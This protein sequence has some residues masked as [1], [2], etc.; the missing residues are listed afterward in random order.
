MKTDWLQQVSARIEGRNV[1]VVASLAFC[2]FGIYV[3]RGLNPPV[4]TISLGVCFLLGAA[5]ILIALLRAPQPSGIVVGSAANPGD[6]KDLTAA[7]AQALVQ[8]DREAVTRNLLQEASRIQSALLPAGAALKRDSLT[9][10]SDSQGALASSSSA[11]APE[12]GGTLMPPKT[13]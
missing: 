8:G 11:G 13:S 6:R 12:G 5:V 10:A 3:T 1:I 2:G 4:S 9:P 7:A